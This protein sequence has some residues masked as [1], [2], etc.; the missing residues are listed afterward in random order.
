[1]F[2]IPFQKHTGKIPRKTVAYHQNLYLIRRGERSIV[3]INTVNIFGILCDT[4]LC[5]IAPYTSS[6][7]GRI[8]IA[9][10]P[11]LAGFVM[12]GAVFVAVA[13]ALSKS[14]TGRE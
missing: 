13:T 6:S 4:E 14:I 2:H 1:M 11:R 12:F 3:G 5:R 9:S 7:I 8:V 10:M